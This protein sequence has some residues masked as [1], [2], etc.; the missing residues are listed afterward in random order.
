MKKRLNTDRV[1]VGVIFGSGHLSLAYEVENPQIVKYVEIPY[2]PVS[3][4]IG[5]GREL[6]YGQVH[7]KNVILFTGRI[8]IFEGYRSYYLTFMG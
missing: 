7:G 2:F 3:T 4:N 6:V 1:D 5:H 8:H